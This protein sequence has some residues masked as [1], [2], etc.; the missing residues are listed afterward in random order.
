MFRITPINQLLYSN[1]YATETKTV[2]GHLER[3]IIF[4]ENVFI[5][6]KTK[7]KQKKLQIL[8]IYLYL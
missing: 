5:L 1:V 6:K 8:I 7:K 3:N 2:E 4:F